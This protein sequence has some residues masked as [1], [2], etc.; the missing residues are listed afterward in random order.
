MADSVTSRAIIGCLALANALLWP[1]YVLGFY[2]SRQRPLVFPAG[3]KLPRGIYFIYPFNV[4]A[5]ACVALQCYFD[6]GAGRI[7]LTPCSP[8]GPLETAVVISGDGL[9]I[10]G[11]PTLLDCDGA[12]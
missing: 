1:F 11:A 6:V 7:R 12:L 8:L 4:R 2:G 5:T 3:A 10:L 9:T